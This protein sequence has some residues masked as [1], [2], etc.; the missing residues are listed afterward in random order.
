M[1]TV[2]LTLGCLIFLIATVKGGIHTGVYTL[3]IYL[4]ILAY[5]WKY[6]KAWDHKI[7]LEKYARQRENI[8]ESSK[9]PGDKE[10]FARAEKHR[11]LLKESGSR[12]DVQVLE[13]Y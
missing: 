2:S 4:P 6:I 11:E 3:L 7:L 5:V 9:Y 10:V 12:L 1:K 13:I 8:Y